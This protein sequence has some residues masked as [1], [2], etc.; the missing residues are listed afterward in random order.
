[1]ENKLLRLL[2]LLLKLP[3]TPEAPELPC[4]IFRAARPFYVYLLLNWG[5]KQIGAASGIAA[6]L[7][8][9]RFIPDFQLQLGPLTLGSLHNILYIFEILAIAAFLAQIPVTLLMVRID[10]LMR[11]Y[12]VTGR[13]LRIREGL[14]TVRELTMSFANIQQITVDRG[15]LQRVLG[16][17]DVKV[18][19]AGGGGSDSGHGKEEQGPNLHLAYFRGVS[20]YE[21]IRQLLR[22]RVNRI[23]G[24]GLGDPD[25]PVREMDHPEA[26]FSLLPT[27]LTGPMTDRPSRDPSAHAVA[28]GPQSGP[29]AGQRADFPAVLMAARQLLEEARELRAVLT[30]PSRRP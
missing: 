3:A 15:P 8:F 4:R 28:A 13:S 21:E 2:E 23:R 14:L 30:P 26:G 11:W 9:T 29:V 1:M 20:D 22:D 19:S 6:G 10:F 27:N 24:S 18:Q 5:L 16:I 7:F 17:A 25:E 12:L